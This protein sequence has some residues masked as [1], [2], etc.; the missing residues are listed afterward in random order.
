MLVR[1]ATATCAA[2][3]RADRPRRAGGADARSAAPRLTKL[4]CVPASD[5]ELPPGRAPDESGARSSCAAAASCAACACR[6]AGR[7]ARWRRSCAAAR[8]GWVAQVPPGTRARHASASRSATAPAGARTRA[9][10]SSR[11]RSRARPLASIAARDAAGRVARQRHVDLAAAEVRRRQPRRDRGA[12]APARACRRSSSRAPTAPTSGRS[13]RPQLVAALHARGLRVC[14]WQFVYGTDPLGEAAAGAGA[15]AQRRRLPRHRRR[16]RLRGPLRGGAALRRRAARGDRPGLPARPDVVPVRR[17]PPAASRTR[18]SSA[19]GGA[20]ANLPQV[21]WKAIGGSVDAVSAKTVAHNRIY[22]A[23]IAPLGQAY[24]APK[25][26]DLA[27][28][29][30]IWAG[31]G[32]GGI[33]WWSWQ[34]SSERD[35]GGADARP[36]RRPS[37]RPTRAGR[38]SASG[39]Q[40]RPGHLAAAAPRSFDRRRRSPSTA[41]SPPRRTRRCAR[42]R[43]RAACRR[44]GTTDAATWQARARAARCGRSTGRRG[45]RASAC[46]RRRR[47]AWERPAPGARRGPARGARPPSAARRRRS[48]RRPAAAHRA[49]DLERQRRVPAVARA[50]AKLTD[51][52]SDPDCTRVRQVD[53]ER[54][55]ERDEAR[56]RRARRRRRARRAARRRP[57]RPRRSRRRA[58][59]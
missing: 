1:A 25:A 16:D 9:T 43:P 55:D 41:S 59:A 19:P 14:A 54:D 26:A 17:L 30:A 47:D 5:R 3:R 45:S 53:G 31:Y 32:A 15:V 4:R 34:A 37:C 40:R 36:R 11:R 12:R 24:D 6:S 13:S 18:S 21:Y 22:G 20:Q 23:P 46:Q 27:R 56:A 51:S 48:R 8:A 28:F 7:G 35:V 52:R 49:G 50:S 38:R 42:S 58:R 33:S 44:P 10:S 2:A 29:R 57:S 39:S